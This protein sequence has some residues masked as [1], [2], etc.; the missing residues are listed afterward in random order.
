MMSIHINT[1]Y[2]DNEGSKS[3]SNGDTNRLAR[4]QGTGGA[5]EEIANHP[6]ALGVA[7]VSR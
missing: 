3:S 5:T 7:E 6:E 2:I 4:W 1:S